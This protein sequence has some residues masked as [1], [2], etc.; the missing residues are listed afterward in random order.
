MSNRFLWSRLGFG[1]A[2][3]SR[4]REEAVLTFWLRQATSHVTAWRCSVN[5][6]LS[7]KR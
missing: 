2:L 5:Y 1:Q 3:P 7:K 4:D 6:S